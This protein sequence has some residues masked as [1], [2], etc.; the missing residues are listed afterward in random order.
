VTSDNSR[1]P[2]TTASVNS[3]CRVMKTYYM[4]Q[5]YARCRQLCFPAGQLG[6]LVGYIRRPFDAA[7]GSVGME[8]E[9]RVSQCEKQ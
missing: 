8:Q 9:F 1:R 5:Q 6:A 4:A 3:G 7:L 2:F